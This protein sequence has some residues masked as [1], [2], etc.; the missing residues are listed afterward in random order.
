MA[1]GAETRTVEQIEERV[2]CDLAYIENW[3]IRF[4]IK[5]MVMTLLREVRSQHAF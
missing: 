4:D 5:I 2:K 3:S 1:G